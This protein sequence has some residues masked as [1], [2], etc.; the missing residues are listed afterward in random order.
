VF[1]GVLAAIGQAGGAVLS[2]KAYALA[3][4]ASQPFRATVGDGL[5][6]AYQRILGGIAVSIC[7]Y[8]YLKLRNQPAQSSRADWQHGAPWLLAHALA[9]PVAGVTC[10]QWALMLKPANIV[11][12]IVATT[13]LVVLP[14]A[15]FFEGEKITRRASVGASIAVAGVV[16]LVQA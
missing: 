2:R 5:D 15:H 9:G 3:A 11:L 13:P 14:L 4:A 6:V 7:F 1:Y 16:G 10:F 12:P 8:A